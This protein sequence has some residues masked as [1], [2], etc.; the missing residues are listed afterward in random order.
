MGDSHL[1]ERERP[2]RASYYL[3]WIFP[4]LSCPPPPD[5]ASWPLRKIS[6][7]I[8]IYR[9]TASQQSTVILTHLCSCLVLLAS[10]VIVKL[11]ARTTDEKKFSYALA[12]K[13]NHSQSTNRSTEKRNPMV[14][15]H[16]KKKWGWDL[17]AQPSEATCRVVGGG[18]EAVVA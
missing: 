15:F 17:V 4:T 5:S 11:A 13:K 16:A 9:I 6:H 18:P 14:F 12:N 3:F 8:P 1:S 2:R 7:L 10:L